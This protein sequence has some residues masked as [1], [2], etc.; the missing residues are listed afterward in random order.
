MVDPA[1]LRGLE[2]PPAPAHPRRVI[3]LAAAALVAIGWID[4][5]TGTELDLFALYFI[6][7]AL[8]SWNA[9]RGAGLASA[10]A[11]AIVWLSADLAGGRA[12]RDVAIA[13][14]N[15]VVELTAFGTVALLVSGNRAALLR[16]R[17]LARRDPL[18]RLDNG[19]A[20][21]DRAEQELARARRRRSPVVV[22][23]LDLDGFKAV[24]D[25]RGHAA[26]DDVLRTIAYE[27]RHRCRTTDA[28]ARLAGD[29]FAF[30]LPD[31]DAAGA[32]IVLEALRASIAEAMKVRGHAVTASV[33]A[34]AFAEA[35]PSVEGLV[36]E[37]DAVMYEA[38]RAGKDRVVVR[39]RTA[40]GGG[41]R[42]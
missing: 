26:G 42:A 40:T 18:T 14:V 37:A 28:A 29:E 24:N 5:A 9:G 16:E 32:R 33:G 21:R 34:V 39:E 6:P 30:L 36:R 31:T 11:S 13:V 38:K 4:L 1:T 23:Y 22:A 41:A 10:T 17:A 27:I 12:E 35:P 15:S 25:E 7:V 20:F 3:A 2:P 8:V 19:I